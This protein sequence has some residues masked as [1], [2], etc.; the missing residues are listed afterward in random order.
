MTLLAS[1]SNDR[2]INEIL[3]REGD[4]YTEHPNDRGGPTK[5]GITL[6][7]LEI[8]RGRK[9]APASVRNLTEDEARYIYEKTYIK[10]PGFDKIEDEQLRGLVVDSGVQ[11]GTSR[12]IVW[13]QKAAGV[14]TDGIIGPITIRAVNNNPG[15]IYNR[16][17]AERIRF[18]GRIISDDPL[19]AKFAAGW[20]NRV[21][22]FVERAII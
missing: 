8:W 3:H 18:Y 21:S 20:A 5:Y 7:A 14:N 9:L 12:A 2:I 10:S 16:L 13:L 15:T 17:L 1:S 6:R 22:E 4:R 11:H 19:Q